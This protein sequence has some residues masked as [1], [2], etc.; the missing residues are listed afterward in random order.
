MQHPVLITRVF[1]APREKI[2]QAWTDPEH[3]KKWWGPK[4]FTSPDAEMDVRPGGKY[5]LSM[6]GTGFP[7]LWSG[8]VYEEVVPME[9]IVVTDFFANENGDFVSPAVYGMEGMPEKMQITLTF[10]DAGEN[11][12]KLSIQYAGLVPEKYFSDMLSGWNSSL[13]KLAESVK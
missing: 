10:E 4:D 11:K 12:T 2:W 9:K 6:L 13:D 1:D 8:G 5:K 7:K 3:I